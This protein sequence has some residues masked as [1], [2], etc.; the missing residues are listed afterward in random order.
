MPESTIYWIIAAIIVVLLVLIILSVLASRRRRAAEAQV[1]EEQLKHRGVRPEPAGEE[2]A[3]QHEDV[4]PATEDAAHE[5]PGDGAAPVQPATAATAAAP[6]AATVPSQQTGA[7]DATAGATRLT[8]LDDTSAPV[9]DRTG[10][11]SE[12]VAGV[13]GGTGVTVDQ[14]QGTVP[15]AAAAA[16]GLGAAGVAGGTGVTLDEKDGT[17]DVPDTPASPSPVTDEA[18]VAAP[19][20]AA[21]PAP[22]AP[23]PSDAA[24][25]P[26]AEDSEPVKGTVP[27]SEETP[28]GPPASDRPLGGDSLGEDEHLEAHTVATTEHGAVVV[29]TAEQKD[30][31]EQNG[32]AARSGGVKTEAAQSKGAREVAE[33]VAGGTGVSVDQRPVQEDLTQQDASATFTETPHAGKIDGTPGLPG[34]VGHEELQRPDADRP[35]AAAGAAAPSDQA[36]ATPPTRRADAPETHAGTT[37]ATPLGGA[38]ELDPSAAAQTGRDEDSV[39]PPTRRE[40]MATPA[41]PAADTTPA[42]TPAA[43]STPTPAPDTSPASTPTDAESAPDD[44]E[45]A[46]LPDLDAERTRHADSRAAGDSKLAQAGAVAA[47]ALGTVR[48]RVAIPL[49]DNVA[50]PVKDKALKVLK[51]KLAQAQERRWGKH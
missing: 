50:V 44:T 19:A 14:Q 20:P 29:V 32:E 1:A 47:T 4:D 34:R 39:T 23:V 10:D 8:R 7:D 28:D 27:L 15:G 49:R 11:T 35:S 30:D 18:P 51:D 3:S 21:Q 12:P 43:P 2:A 24:A 22:V 37:P 41:T 33:G 6:L 38:P 45:G 16:V 31:A 36:E 5:R 26:V 17:A 9:T 42:S 46:S 13:A 48:D 40:D 25:S